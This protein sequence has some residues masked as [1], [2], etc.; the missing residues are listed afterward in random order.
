MPVAATAF[1]RSGHE[2]DQTEIHSFVPQARPT[3]LDRG[4]LHQNS[5]L[6]GPG[7]SSLSQVGPS[8]A[9]VSRVSGSSAVTWDRSTKHSVE[10]DGRERRALTVLDQP[11][12]E[13][14]QDKGSAGLPVEDGRAP[15][16]H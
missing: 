10:L 15:G 1:R 8:P 5:D 11:S 16:Q 2:V 12:V 3:A 13:L 9:P 6:T 14:V 7:D 4:T